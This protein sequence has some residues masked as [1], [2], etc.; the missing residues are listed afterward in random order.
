[1]PSSLSATDDCHDAYD[2]ACSSPSSLNVETDRLIIRPVA[3][4]DEIAINA[5]VIATY[6]HLSKWLPWA[7]GPTP[8]T[9]DESRSFVQHCLQESKEGKGTV[10]SC[11][12]KESPSSL[13]VMTGNKAT[14][15]DVFVFYTVSDI[16]FWTFRSF[17]SEQVDS[18]L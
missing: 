4:G 14:L 17:I 3:E 9:M 8:P 7:A 2:S 13:V 5:A 18:L 10:I 1:M 15:E 6:E 12:L 16:W 11:W